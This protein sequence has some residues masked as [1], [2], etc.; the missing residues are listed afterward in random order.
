MGETSA[1]ADE[2][3][4]RVLEFE[5]IRERLAAHASWAGGRELALALQ[6]AVDPE[7]VGRR[8]DETGEGLT[9]LEMEGFSLAGIRDVRRAV[10]RAQVGATLDPAEL[11]DV[12]STLSASRRLQNLLRENRQLV[13]RL[14]TLA[15]QLVAFPE[16]EKSITTA[17]T[18]QAEVADN[19]SPRLA[20]I[21]RSLR[22]LQ[23]RLRSQM[24]SIIRS[25]QYLRWLQDPIITVREGRYVVPVKVEARAQVPGIIHDQSASGA[26]LFIEP[27][28]AVELNNELRRLSLEEKEEVAR[29]LGELSAAVGQYGSHLRL[30]LEAL[31]HLDMVIARAEYAQ[32]LEASRPE[33]DAGG[34]LEFRGARHPLLGCQAVPID[35]SLGD[36][37]DTLVISGPNT[38]GKTVALKT[39]GLLTLMAQAGL[40]LPCRP[41]SR[42]GVFRRVFADIGDEQ[43]IE[44]NLST[45]SSHMRNIVNTVRHAG[46]GTMVLLDELGAGTDPAQGAALGM[47]ILDYLQESGCRTV[48]T[49]HS[50][51]LKSYAYTHPRVESAAVE[52]DPVTLEPSY[53]LQVG[54]PGFSN[55]FAI[56]ARLGLPSSLVEKARSLMSPDQQQVE[57][58]LAGLARDRQLAAEERERARRAA[59]E[60]ERARADAIGELAEV[61][62]RQEEML[63]R[64]RTQA[65]RIADEARRELETVSRA[66]RRAQK[67][68]DRLQR[69]AALREAREALRRL[70]TEAEAIPAHGRV[71]AAPAAH[72]GVA[73]ASVPAAGGR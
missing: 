28:V 7:E 69:E 37:F 61:R 46:P 67:E 14:A 38:G 57:A 51:E 25:S 65:Q 49:T 16:L 64:A 24:E 1:V 59:A 53:R 19:A 2:Y 22:L 50:G 41:G 3:T 45:F 58:L 32:A 23:D 54:T 13:P 42:A 8:L 33:L 4:L 70:R 73:R 56:A 71:A 55:A 34:S 26:T 6:P 5:K 20:R 47:A 43:S 18:P 9:L 31:A 35:V 29:I 48:V 62:A 11:L 52:F 12:A 15:E 30:A 60:A 40:Y 21:R 66:V 36:A 10:A 44:Q 39:V 68:E 72:E 63:A 27:M 17:I